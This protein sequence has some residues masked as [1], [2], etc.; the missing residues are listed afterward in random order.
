MSVS[1]ISIRQIEYFLKVIEA[2]S[3]IKAAE[4]VH[5]TPQAIS[6][7]VSELEK[8]LGVTL[9]E[10]SGRNIKPTPEAYEL[11][12]YA[13]KVLFATEEMEQQAHRHTRVAT[14]E[15]TIT[16]GLLTVP[17]RGTLLS[18]GL[19]TQFES[20]YPH[21]NLH[22]EAYANETCIDALRE[23]M[24]DAA[25]VLDKPSPLDDDIRCEQVA[26]IRPQ[27]VLRE[28]HPLACREYISLEEL[29]SFPVATPSN[30]RYAMSGL[31]RA[32]TNRDL[33]PAFKNIEP[34]S[35]AILAFLGG[36]GVLL[37]FDT[38]P[39]PAR[40]DNLK[41]VPLASDEDLTWPVFVIFRKSTQPSPLPLLIAH[42]RAFS[43]N[44]D[45]SSK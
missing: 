4:N 6:K 43:A 3:C 15:G 37:A 36:N 13:R 41:T 12:G 8:K 17:Y 24:I 30:L 44:F 18:K 35:E 32:F 7:A 21:V 29:A 23:K 14:E 20:E 25:V 22:I 26:S 39:L 28:S 10:R 16:L 34:S 1:N 19:F 9:L 33:R 27:A 31:R 38:T 2:G 40:F 11:V 45:H 42:L 5:V